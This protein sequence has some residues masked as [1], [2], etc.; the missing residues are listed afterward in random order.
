[1]GQG[2]AG[3]AWGAIVDGLLVGIL[4]VLSIY[5][6]GA[7]FVKV[8]IWGLLLLTLLGRLRGAWRR[9]GADRAPIA[10][11]TVLALVGA[12]GAAV[13]VS[14]QQSLGLWLLVAL[15]MAVSRVPDEQPLPA[16]LVRLRREAEPPSGSRQP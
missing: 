5:I 13:T 1:M 2:G 4:E 7:D 3:T 11:G 8:P 15:G 10:A 12:L 16:S 6:V 9:R 14:V